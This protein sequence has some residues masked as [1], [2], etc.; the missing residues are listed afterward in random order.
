MKKGKGAFRGIPGLSQYH[1]TDTFLT[2]A[3][4]LEMNKA[5]TKAVKQDK[6]F[7]AYM[8][9]YAVHSPFESDPRFE[10]NY[11]SDN[12]N[13]NAF[14]T[15]IEGMDKSLGDMLDHLEELG[16]A[17][18]TLVLF[19]GDNG[20][21]APIGPIHDIACAAPLRG[22]KGTHYEGGMRVPFI[23]AWA[24]ANPQ[25][26]LQKKI[27]ISE[28]TITN[29][30][31]TVYD[32]VPTILEASDV[33][34]TKGTTFDGLNLSHFFQKGHQ[35]KD[36]EFLMHFPHKHRSSYFTAFRQDDWKLIYHYPTPQAKFKT[37]LFHL[38]EDRDESKNL[39][40]SHPEKLQ[41]MMKDMLKSLKKAGAQFPLSEDKK[42]VLI[43][44]L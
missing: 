27:K 2:E 42:S 32:L 28:N 34:I 26:P 3:L 43:P 4:T 11:H 18:D 15:L 29:Q 31:G 6:P 44:K 16:V 37:E 17:E 8:S 1:G 23:A 40:Q 36:R 25:N 13:L 41:Q 9:H 10:K 20:T 12:K 38:R 33:S 5:L 30:L 21:D 7:F 19:L 14:A 22:K 39:A 35:T 24:K